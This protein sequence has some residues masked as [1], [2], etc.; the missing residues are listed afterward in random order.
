MRNDDINLLEINKLKKPENFILLKI[1]ISYVDQLI[2]NKPIH[3]RRVWKKQK[4]WIV[5]RINP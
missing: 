5:E 1:D 2:L 3:I 4:K